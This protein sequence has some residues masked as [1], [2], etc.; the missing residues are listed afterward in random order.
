VIHADLV[1]AGWAEAAREKNTYVK[2]IGHYF[3]GFGTHKGK[4]GLVLSRK[5]VPE[6]N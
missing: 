3:M 2:F 1:L 5:Q 4:G 6:R